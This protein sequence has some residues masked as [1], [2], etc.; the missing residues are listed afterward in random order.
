MFESGS[1]KFFELGLIQQRS[2][3]DEVSVQ[4]AHMGVPNQGQHVFT[5]QWFAA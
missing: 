4:I 1:L 3:R 5:N 2:A